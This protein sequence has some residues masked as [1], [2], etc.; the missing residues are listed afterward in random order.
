MKK[1]NM[2]FGKVLSCDPRCDHTVT[3]ALIYDGDDEHVARGPHLASE[4]FC[5]AREAFGRDHGSL[6]VSLLIT[7]SNNAHITQESY[8]LLNKPLLEFYRVR[9][10]F[11]FF[12]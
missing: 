11:F 1:T 2:R 12:C 9:V 10:S 7:G 5:V 8:T 4:K 6:E 3:F